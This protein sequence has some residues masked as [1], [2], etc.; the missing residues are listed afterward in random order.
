MD[1][2]IRLAPIT[3]IDA[4]VESNTASTT[5]QEATTPLNRGAVAVHGAGRYFLRPFT[6][7]LSVAPVLKAG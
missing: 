5:S 2:R 6:L 1:A 3:S 7:V 4:A